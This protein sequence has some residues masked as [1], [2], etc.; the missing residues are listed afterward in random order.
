MNK[1]TAEKNKTKTAS[2]EFYYLC[3]TDKLHLHLHNF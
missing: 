2:N 3:V 1:G